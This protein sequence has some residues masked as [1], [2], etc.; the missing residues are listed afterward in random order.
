MSEN[1]LKFDCT[2]RSGIATCDYIRMDNCGA[3][4]LIQR[5]RV[6][7]GFILLEDINNCNQLASMCFDLQ[8]ATPA[9][10]AKHNILSGSRNG[11]I[12]ATPTVLRSTAIDASKVVTASSN[13]C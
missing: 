6:F 7:Q 13:K 4:G 9:S 5:I 11:L 2:F 1:Y 12:T 10:Y 3:H 8:V